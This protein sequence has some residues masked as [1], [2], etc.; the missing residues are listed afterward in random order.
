LLVARPP[1]SPLRGAAASLIPVALAH[2]RAAAGQLVR[3]LAGYVQAMGG[4]LVL[5]AD[6]GSDQVVLG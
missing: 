5:V 3:T 2:Y 6:F 1:A 4:Q